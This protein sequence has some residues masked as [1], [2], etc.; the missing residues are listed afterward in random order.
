MELFKILGTIAI[1]G[2]DKAEKALD[3][4]TG[5]A[6][7]VQ[8][9]FAPVTKAIGGAAVALGGAGVAATKLASDYETAFAQVN[10]LLTGSESDIQAYKDAIIQASNETG[11][12]TTEMSAAIY[13]AI[14]AGVD[15]GKAIEFTTEAM[16]LAKG[17]FTDATT[18]VDILTTA[19][20][21]YGLESSDATNIANKLITT[22]NLGKT[23][24]DELASSMGKV[25]PTAKT[26]GVDIDDLCGMYATMTS[27]GIATAETTTYMNSMLNE[28]GKQGT[29]AA[30]AFAAGTEHIKEGGLT[31]KE[32]MEMGWE[33]T[34]VLSVL[35]EEAA[36]SGTSINN[37]FGSA[38][39]GKAAGVLWDNAQK[40][41][42]SVEAMGNSAGATEEA[43]KKMD[44]TL[45]SKME[46]MKTRFQNVGIELGQKLFPIVEKGMTWVEEHMPEI[47]ANIDKLVP[48]ISNLIQIVIEK[49]V[50]ALTK[51]LEYVGKVVDWFVNLD[52]GQKKLIVTIVA[53]LALISPIAGVIAGITTALGACA[54]VIGAISAPVLI[55]I[56]V[57]TALIAIGVLLYKNWDTIKE[58]ASELAQ[59][60][61]ETFSKIKD[62]IKEKI[63]GAKQAV[64]D[65]IDKIKSFFKFEWAL[66]KLKLPHFKING[67]FSLNP[68][69]VPSFGIE[70]YK[71]AM[72]DP[73]IMNAPTAFGLNKNG[74][75]MAGG[76]AGSEV[77]S[78]TD[79]LMNMIRAAVGEG[80]GTAD[81]AEAVKE[82]VIE[83]LSS[84]DFSASI[85]IEPDDRRLFKVV[86]QQAKIIK[87]STGRQVFA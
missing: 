41:N 22:Q 37:L 18:A 80:S 40:L 30:D 49:G 45:A 61:S 8:S 24:V 5:T 42:E 67:S 29:T 6:K 28:L 56:G 11:K 60:V 4:V 47:Q 54:A 1:E 65:G 48:I 51:V 71:K 75:I 68:P 21:A 44:D 85:K 9:T 26:L 15:Q 74:Q 33:L 19:I 77:V 87:K 23:T 27:N 63:D 32:A 57:I 78:G 70:W 16:K 2:A 50:P 20:N 14:S 84:F 17:G 64:K 12:S 3:K 81:I 58:K 38:E 82:A 31:M 79:T 7:K 59:K 55:V 72:D 46:K 53:V 86:E 25:I 36:A 39:A 69:S 76:E 73:M 10:T 83:G 62:T 13:N 34:D 66:P 35:D 43:Y 52:D